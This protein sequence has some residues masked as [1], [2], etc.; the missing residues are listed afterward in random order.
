MV[1]YAYFPSVMFSLVNRTQDDAGT[2]LGVL[3][4]VSIVYKA[5]HKMR[6]GEGESDG[7]NKKAVEGEPT[8]T[9][10]DP[11][12]AS[13]FGWTVTQW[14]KPANTTWESAREEDG[15]PKVRDISAGAGRLIRHHQY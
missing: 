15:S 2:L 1:K 14:E 11:S 3:R 9:M 4:D 8:P 10:N 6:M 7:G 12:P 13:S 5:I